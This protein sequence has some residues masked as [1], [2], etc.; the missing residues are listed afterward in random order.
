MMEPNKRIETLLKKEIEEAYERDLVQVDNLLHKR[1]DVVQ[2][3]PHM[4]KR[5]REV[6]LKEMGNGQEVMIRKAPAW[7]IASQNRMATWKV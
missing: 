4:K 6:Y 7:W 2:E 1:W 3:I 5:K